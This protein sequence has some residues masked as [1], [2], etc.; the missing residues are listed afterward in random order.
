MQNFYIE[1]NK[2]LLRKIKDDL[3]KWREKTFVDWKIQLDDSPP[4]IDL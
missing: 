4:Q 3:S 2:T 1:N